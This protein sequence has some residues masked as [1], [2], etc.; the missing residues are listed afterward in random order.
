MSLGLI[1]LTIC[2]STPA[3]SGAPFCRF[4]TA[5]L[6]LLTQPCLGPVLRLHTYLH[7]MPCLVHREQFEIPSPSHFLCNTWHL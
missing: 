2:A 1:G 4:W 6:S 7:V 3:S 5:F